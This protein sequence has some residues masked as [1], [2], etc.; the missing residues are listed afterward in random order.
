MK[1]YRK[2]Q[3][4]VQGS[5]AKQGESP[6]GEVRSGNETDPEYDGTR[7]IQSEAGGTIRQ[8]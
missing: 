2:G 4:N 3:P 7:G 8:G 1:V 5:T 6:V